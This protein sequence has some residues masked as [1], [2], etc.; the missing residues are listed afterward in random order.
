[1]LI[2]WISDVVVCDM[3]S[4]C[5]FL[6][7]VSCDVHFFER[8]LDIGEACA[9]LAGFLDLNKISVSYMCHKH[10]TP[11]RLPYESTVN[12]C[13]GRTRFSLGN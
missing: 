7:W 6:V 12:Y 4:L 11:Q 5:I 1:M 8:F 10:D 3:L 13:V 2:V 9:L